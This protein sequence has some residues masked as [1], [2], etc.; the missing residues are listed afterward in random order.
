MITVYDWNGHTWA[1]WWKDDETEPQV[2][3]DVGL[4]QRDRSQQYIGMVMDFDVP[5]GD[6]W[7]PSEP[8][9]DRYVMEAIQVDFYSGD[10][11]L[12]GFVRV[13][14]FGKGVGA[15]RGGREYRKQRWVVQTGRDE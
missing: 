13:E 4:R 12:E 11:T 15:D 8:G 7:S 2:F 6:D 14:R 1:G 10:Y 9:V 3:K 5:N